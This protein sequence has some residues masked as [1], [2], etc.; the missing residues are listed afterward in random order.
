MV[1]ISFGIDIILNFFTGFYHTGGDNDG[2]L[3]YDQKRIAFRYMRSFFIIDLVATIPF[4]LIFNSGESDNG[5]NRSAKLVNL[6]KIMKLLR[7]LKLLR[8]YRLQKFIREV[9]SIYNVHHGISR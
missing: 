5:V 4:D 3:C 7:G 6:G 9:E 8:V 1:D 2:N